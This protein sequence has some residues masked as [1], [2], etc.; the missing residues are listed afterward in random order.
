MNL[1]AQPSAVQNCSGKSWHEFLN[2]SEGG[3]CN[4]SN[5]P[6]FL[7]SSRFLSLIYCKAD[8]I[9]AFSISA[10]S[11][12]VRESEVFSLIKSTTSSTIK[13]L[14][15]SPSPSSSSSS[16]SS[17][18]STD[19]SSSNKCFMTDFLLVDGKCLLLRESNLAVI[20]IGSVEEVV[21]TSYDSITVE[22]DVH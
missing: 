16:S 18:P 13:S 8:S 5:I 14:Q 7:T 10:L 4:V 17:S 1:S 22:R 9:I 12:A 2:S 20:V 21:S 19:T 3:Y 6:I 15:S 11:S